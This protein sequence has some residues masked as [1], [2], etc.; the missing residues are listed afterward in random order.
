MRV[1]PGRILL[2]IQEPTAREPR[3]IAL[4][5][6]RETHKRALKAQSQMMQ[7][8]TVFLTAKGEGRRGERGRR[9]RPEPASGQDAQSVPRPVRYALDHDEPVFDL[10][11]EPAS[12][13]S[14][15][16]IDHRHPALPQA[17]CLLPD[18]L[19]SRECPTPRSI[20]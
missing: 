15:A 19:G 3:A 13:P 9:H 2:W 7:G 18:D 5:Y 1:R 16:N 10:V 4:P 17:G 12:R 20:P 11:D 6:S 8:Q 14:N